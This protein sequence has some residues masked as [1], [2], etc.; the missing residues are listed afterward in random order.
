MSFALVL[1]GGGSAAVAWEIGVI[2][3][4]AE[5]GVDIRT[6]ETMIGTS[7]GSIVAVRLRSD[8]S[9]SAL[10]AQAS[11]PVTTE[12]MD[13][14]FADLNARWALATEG[15]T[16]A[17]E[18]RQRIG[19]LAL[20]ATT[21]T[22]AQR[23]AEIAAM[24]PLARWPGAPVIATAVS[25]RT[26][27]FRTLTAEDGVSLLDAVCA[28]CA[29]PGVWP[30]V[31][32]D[33]EPFIDGAVRSPTNIGTAAGHTHVLVLAPM[34]PALGGGL[35]RELATLGDAHHLVITADDDS[36]RAFGNNPL[37]LNT[38]PAAAREGRRQGRQAA[39]GVTDLLSRT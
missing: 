17:E 23:R 1:G 3:G 24:L 32:I 34:A 18:A 11:A 35:E 22:P 2:A 30:P 38:G 26:G 39:Q 33:D 14:D 37:D 19:A 16:S 29:V 21:M 20:N 5:Q 10:F 27:R 13:L 4:L 36:Q 15:A 12:P 6:A 31:M 25:A 8:L 7:A 9:T 28:S